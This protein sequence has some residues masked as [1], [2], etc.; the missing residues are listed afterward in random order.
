MNPSHKVETIEVALAPSSLGTTG[1]VSFA[2][3]L[4]QVA[5][6]SAIYTGNTPVK[7]AID[8][9]VKAGAALEA[10]ATAK[11]TAKQV[12]FTAIGAEVA[13]QA[14]YDVAAGVVRGTLPL[15][16]KTA[17]D[18]ESLGCAR[19]VKSA[20]VP[21]VPPV[22][23]T[24]RPDKDPGSIYTHA[25]RISGLFRYILEI[26]VDPVTPTSWEEQ[27]GGTATRK[28]TGLVSGKLYWLRW[29]TERGTK[30]STWSVPISVTAK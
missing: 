20:S 27:P 24:G 16:C 17:Q 8:A 23:V 14:A 25:H 4:A 29:C 22:L 1:R 19:K 28:L 15:Y 9:L 6:Q 11:E 26:S 18:L 7:T 13:A 10:A 21:L 12:Y 30:R 5:P 2:A 3:M